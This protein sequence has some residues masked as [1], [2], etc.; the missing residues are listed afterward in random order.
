MRWLDIY[1]QKAYTIST[2]GRSGA[3]GVARVKTYANVFKDYRYHP[4]AKSLAPSGRLCERSDIGLLKRR[5]VIASWVALIGKES[6][7]LELVR[8][9]LI[10]G[11]DQV[12]SEYEQTGR[13]YWIEVIL[14]ILRRMPLNTLKE[15]SGMSASALKAIRSIGKPATAHMRNRMLLERIALAWMT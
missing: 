13:N 3:V 8:A 7:E 14:P 11:A 10:H 2:S 15:R 12:Y 1:S 4:E 5:P 9:G 6:N